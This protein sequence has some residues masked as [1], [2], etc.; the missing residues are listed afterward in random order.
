MNARRLVAA[1]AI[2][3]AWLWPAQAISQPSPV[4]GPPETARPRAAP[5]QTPDQQSQRVPLL[6]EP[7]AS[8]PVTMIESWSLGGSAELGLGRFRVMEIARPRT[9]TE[10][11]RAPLNMERETRPIA[12]AGLSIRFR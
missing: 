11:Q 8:A 12:G 5:E 1:L 7:A 2:S 3:C 9:H 10:R 6:E 4:Y